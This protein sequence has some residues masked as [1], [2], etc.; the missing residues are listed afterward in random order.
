MYSLNYAFSKLFHLMTIKV[1][2]EVESVSEIDVSKVINSRFK[3]SGPK[4]SKDK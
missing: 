1:H 2:L 4:T 3:Q